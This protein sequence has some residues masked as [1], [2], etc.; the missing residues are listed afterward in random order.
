MP[1]L[2]RKAQERSKA[3]CTNLP[4]FLE[5]RGHMKTEGSFA[6]A[7][8]AAESLMRD[9]GLFGVTGKG[10]GRRGLEYMLSGREE[11]VRS[12]ELKLQS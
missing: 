8:T 7:H 11:K 2:G 1:V 4:C 10:E 3:Y 6:I 5:I 9:E 12:T